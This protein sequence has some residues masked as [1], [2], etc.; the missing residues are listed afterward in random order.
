MAGSFNWQ[1]PAGGKR[2]MIRVQTGFVLMKIRGEE[3]G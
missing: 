3:Y 1:E 2:M